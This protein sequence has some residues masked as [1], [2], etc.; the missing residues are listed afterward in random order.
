MDKLSDVATT[1]RTLTPHT[2]VTWLDKLRFPLILILWVAIIISFGFMYL[3]F[4]T[5]TSYLVYTQ[6]HVP[7]NTIA[8][9]IYFSFVAATTTGFGDITPLGV[10]KIVSIIEVLLGLLLLA[11]VTSKLVSIKQDA[12]LNELYELSFNESISKLRSSFLLFRQNLDRLLIKI[13]E[14]SASKRDMSTLST[15][16]SSLEHA[17]TETFVII[18]RKPTH[19]FIKNVDAVNTELIFNSILHSL[20]KLQELIAL[21]QQH[22]VEWKIELNT[23]LLSNCLALTENLFSKLVSSRSLSKGKAADLVAQKTALV[24]SLQSAMER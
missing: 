19:G 15:H 4:S 22:A 13:E 16:L 2:V 21:L 14:G 20:E 1:F 24:S 6:S 9:A 7:V 10:F 11:L 17:L 23:L 8:D 12:I 18:G 3:F 5:D